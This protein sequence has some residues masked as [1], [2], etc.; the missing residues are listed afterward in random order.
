MGPRVGPLF[1][2]SPSG[3]RLC[4]C[5]SALF[6][7]SLEKDSTRYN[8]KIDMPTFSRAS[9]CA[10]L[11]ASVTLFAA[12]CTGAEPDLPEGWVRYA[13]QAHG[14]SLSLPSG[15][16]RDSDTSTDDKIVFSGFALPAG[17]NLVRKNLI[18]ISGAADILKGGEK[19]PGFTSHGVTF[20]RAKVY[21]GSAGH[22]TLHIVYTW[23]KGETELHFDFTHFAAN[24]LAFDP[25]DRPKEYDPAAQIKL[26]EE[27]MGMFQPLQHE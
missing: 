27:I 6:L 4:D 14:F 26:S 25:P 23:K 9:R 18:I 22:M 3:S 12:I 7:D 11:T 21:D 5:T 24:V 20:E 10:I 13:D 15:V 16:K 1:F 2:A 17:T 19:M 8:V